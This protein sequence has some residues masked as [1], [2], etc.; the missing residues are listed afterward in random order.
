[1]V[2]QIIKFN[3]LHPHNIIKNS[4]I[5]YSFQG[6]EHDDEIKGEGNFINFTYRGYEPLIGRFHQLDPLT[7]DFPHNSPYTFSENVAINAIELE[8]RERR[9]VFNSA[10][11]SAKALTAIKT[12][13]YDEVKEY[14]DNLAGTVFSTPKDLK[15]AKKMLGKNFDE[16]AGYGKEGTIGLSSGNRAVRGSYEAD[17][18]TAD[19]FYIRLVIDNGNGTWSVKEAK[20]TDYAGRIKKIDAYIGKLDKKIAK[21]ENKI[22][23]LNKSIDLIA[24]TDLSGGVDPI[25]T[26]GSKIVDADPG[27]D[28]YEAAQGT[29]NLD[30]IR[31]IFSAKKQIE[32]LESI[33]EKQ[34]QRKESLK[35]KSNIEYLN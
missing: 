2:I 23:N 9:Y 35:Q 21:L 19:Y 1:M 30:K 17:N 28:Y 16:S 7:K 4:F 6:Q 14:M 3:K 24:E 20:V 8:G 33:K 18:S 12:M 13:P 5:P 34:N 25:T 11:L 32:K 26:R 27:A 31:S 15:F 10:Y 29:R 22:E